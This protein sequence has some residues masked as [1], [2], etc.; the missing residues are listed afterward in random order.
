M[1]LTTE[2]QAEHIRGVVSC[3]DRIIFQGTLPPFCY[4]E[5][6]TSFLYKKK[7][8]IFDYKEH[9]AQPLRDALIA[10]AERIARD[11][12][13]AIDY[14]EKSNFRKEDRIA[15]ILKMRGNHPGMVHIFSVLESCTAYEP[16]HGKKTHRA[17]LKPTAGKCLHYYFYFI[18]E[19]LGLCHVCLQTWIPFRMQIYFNGHNVLAS[20]LN[21]HRI[22]YQMIDNAFWEAIFRN[23]CLTV[24]W[25]HYRRY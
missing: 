15:E 3:Y 9:F 7:I 17:F 12:G 14:L 19:A 4:A 22:P 23:T 24:L 21:K 11:S 25:S 16:W 2:T 6:M 5:G 1:K 20:Q 8:R 13:L 10:N 18:H